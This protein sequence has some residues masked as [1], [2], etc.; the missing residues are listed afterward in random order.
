MSNK[1]GEWLSKNFS[2]TD[3]KPELLGNDYFFPIGNYT[4][5]SLGS[6]GD[7][8][9]LKDFLEVPEV[10]TV[11]NYRAWA[12]SLVQLQVI[13]KET[14]KPAPD[15][16]PI[17]KL[18]K[19]PNFF[20]GQKELWRQTEIFR[21]IFGNEYLYFLSPFGVSSRVKAMFTLPP[22][23]TKIDYPI[24]SQPFYLN[25]EF[26]PGI[27]HSYYWN[28]KWFPIPNEMILHLNDNNADQKPDN[29]LS[30]TSKLLPLQSNIQNIRAAYQA[31][32]VILEN[33][34]AL[35][36]LSN[37]SKDG[38]GSAGPMTGP[39]KEKLQKEYKKKF[40]IQK[41]QWQLIITSLNLKYQKINTDLDKLRVYKETEEDFKMVCNEYGTPFELFQGG[42]DGLFGE[43]KER[44]EKQFFQNTVI[45][46]SQERIH[47]VSDYLIPGDSVFRLIGTFDHLP[48]FQDDIK[49]RTEALN[50]LV[51]ALNVMLTDGAI[52]L[53]DYKKELEKFNIGNKK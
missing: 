22:Q 8:Q 49:E 45:P 31:R 35:G 9:F 23:F 5:L 50:T 38:T 3:L 40:G 13:S 11:I 52:T 15:N 25:T 21:C 36:I 47:A 2:S 34:G 6:S 30:G 4:G 27:K 43:D 39:E 20:Q 17:V 53:D 51:G 32:N 26:P 37:N 18:L 48:I 14:K 12:Q 41:K 24:N 46:T 7:S 33:Y 29:Y 19:N 42:K 10:N 44:V 16:N 28:G 1:I